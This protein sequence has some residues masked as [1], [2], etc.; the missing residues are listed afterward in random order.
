MRFM[1]RKLSAL[2]IVLVLAAGIAQAGMNTLNRDSIP[3]KYKW[4]LNQIYADWTAWEQG[5][6]QLQQLMD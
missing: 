2:T 4:D 1:I 5:L 6:T 3:D